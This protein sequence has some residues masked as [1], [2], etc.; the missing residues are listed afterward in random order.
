MKVDK[1][2]KFTDRFLKSDLF[3]YS[4]LSFVVIIG[5]ASRFYK[6]NNPLTDWHSWRQ[7]DTASVTKIYKQEGLDLLRPRY[8]D[9]SRIQTG[10]FNP[11]GFR[12]V[13]FPLFNIL[14]LGVDQVYTGSFE[15]AGRLVSILTALVLMVVMF[16]LGSKLWG[17][18]GG[19]W[20]LFFVAINP[21]TIYYTRVILPD[22]LAVTMGAT[23]VW[24]FYLFYVS[25]RKFYL[26]S[27]AVVFS[28]ALL[29]KPFGIFYALPIFYLAY[30]KYGFKKLFTNIPLLL[31]L[32]IAF[33]PVFL[34]RAWMGQGDYLVGI[35]HTTSWAFNGDGIR[36][37]PAFWRW[38][39]GERL[40]QLI[41]GMWG[42]IPVSAG[43]LFTRLK[44]ESKSGYGLVIFYLLSVI[45]YLTVVAT[46]NVK[47]DYYQLYL[48]PPLA[49][50][51]SRGIVSLWSIKLVN[52][53]VFVFLLTFSIVLMN[54]ISLY[55]VK[56][57]YKIN[58]YAII[59]AGK[60]ADEFLP[61]DALVIAPYNGSTAFLYQT[62]RKGWP[63]VDEGIEGMIEKGADYFISSQPE[64]AD[65]VNFKQ[66]YKV[67]E[68]D[69]DY[70]IL[71]LHQK[72]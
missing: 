38:I 56:D 49:L 55:L 39:F 20:A 34:W 11:Q 63:V 65:T 15:T 28:L 54:G 71:D 46:A 22:P 47:H 48:I 17:F 67:V 40:G 52:K 16:G 36:F 64:S 51:F 35:P 10:Y 60:R 21:Y 6:I 2:K 31:A 68:E 4:L 44:K 61:K 59:Q 23:A 72:N 66:V 27:S 42:L 26:Y 5:I 24:L 70:V 69:D 14:H 50:L 3:K 19:F 33:I 58:D 30:E 57:Y 41:L 25:D 8:Q 45:F 43:I 18:W 32:D 7:A 62:G 9:I 53:L 37:R 12:F 1:L 29:A 13:E